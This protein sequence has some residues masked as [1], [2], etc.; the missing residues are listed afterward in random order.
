MTEPVNTGGSGDQNSGGAGAEGGE[1]Q[2]LT[3]EVWIKDQPEAV[4]TLLEGQQR[5][6]KS[7]LDN[8]RDARK[9]LEKQLRDLAG[10]AE[11]GSELEKQL[12][13]LIG[14]Q[15]QAEARAAFYEDAHAA[16]ITN[17]KLAWIVAGSDGLIDSRGRVD[18]AGMKQ[19]YPELFGA[20]TRT[21]PGNAGSGTHQ[22][23]TGARSM[24]EFI[25]AA[26]G[27]K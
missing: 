1:G 12:N 27:R 19:R 4:K 22:P 25:R 5:G 23:G 7:A 24:N 8:E 17:L 2:G 13:E 3:F 26:A 10:K 6:V 16:G 15:A 11:K 18:F 20:A 9:A 21:A 14:Q